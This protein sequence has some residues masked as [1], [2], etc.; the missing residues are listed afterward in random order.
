MYLPSIIQAFAAVTIAVSGAFAELQDPAVYARDIAPKQLA[1]L[2]KYR[3]DHA[4]TLTDAHTEV[5]SRAENAVRNFAVEEADAITEACNAAFGE[6][7]CKHILYGRDRRASNRMRG[8][9]RRQAIECHCTD[10]DPSSDC[11]DGYKCQYKFLDCAFNG[12][13]VVSLYS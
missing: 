5:I 10:E 3:E 12:K 11:D 2:A 7:E 1:H 9:S 4:G 6:D 8:L 13:P